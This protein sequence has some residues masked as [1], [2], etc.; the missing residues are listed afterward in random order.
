[1][2]APFNVGSADLRDVILNNIGGGAP[3]CTNTRTRKMKFDFAI[4]DI[5]S[6]LLLLKCTAHHMRET[7]DATAQ[8]KHD[9]MSEYYEF[10][11]CLRSPAGGRLAMQP[12]IE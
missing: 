5:M 1:M 12:G 4:H 6:R 10:N 2:P 9:E 7:I 11:W 8:S 3:T